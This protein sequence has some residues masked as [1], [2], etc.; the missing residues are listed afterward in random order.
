[1]NFLISLITNI[2]HIIQSNGAQFDCILLFCFSPL[3]EWAGYAGATRG[4]PEEL[5]LLTRIEEGA[6]CATR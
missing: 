1:M 2:Q 3:P 6:T 4:R 5:L